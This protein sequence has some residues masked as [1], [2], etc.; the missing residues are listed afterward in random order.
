M[1]HIDVAKLFEGNGHISSIKVYNGNTNNSIIAWDGELL[2]SDENTVDYSYISPMQ[3]FFVEISSEDEENDE[4]A[5][6]YTEDMLGASPETD[7]LRSV[8]GAAGGNIFRLTASA[9]G[10]EAGALLRFSASASD[11]YRDGEDADLL[12][13]DEVPPVV[14]LFTLAGERAVDIQQRANGGEIPLGFFLAKP[15]EMTLRLDVPEQC[16]GWTLVDAANGKAYPLEV[17]LNEIEL[18]RM[19]TNVGRFALRGDLPT[20]NGVI[21]ASQPRIY[22]Y[23]EEGGTL[24]VRSVE[25][26]MTQCEVYTVAGQLLGMARHETNEYR[27]PVASGAKIIRV[28]FADGISSTIKTF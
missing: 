2:S 12:I 10:K 9:A 13:D 16:A 26:L 23:R 7:L 17:G 25:G 11:Y 20:G 21:T 3:S 14:A 18:G 6:T 19:T 4:C 5:I 1:T 27:L 8:R 24:V 22:C 15:E 28:T